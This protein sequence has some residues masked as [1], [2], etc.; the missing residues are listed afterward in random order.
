M[1]KN[2]F[3]HS[4]IFIKKQYFNSLKKNHVDIKT[5]ENS[6]PEKI[7]SFIGVSIGSGIGIYSSL[8]SDSTKNDKD[9]IE[10]I[11]IVPIISIP[12]A[13]LGYYIGG[14]IG[15]IYPVSIPLFLLLSYKDHKYKLKKKN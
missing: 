10:S 11:L 12:L 15:Y 3:R 8:Y 4:H 13:F 7:G 9:F 6:L 2:I 14:F 5:N 1:F